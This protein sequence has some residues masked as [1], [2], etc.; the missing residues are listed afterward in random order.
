[1]ITIE[2]I[3]EVLAGQA[4]LDTIPDSWYTGK[5]VVRARLQEGMLELIPV[6]NDKINIMCYCC[7]GGEPDKGTF[8]LDELKGAVLALK[9]H[10]CPPWPG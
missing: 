2:Q 9:D 10:E 8:G 4:D 6:D 3:K 1:M 5:P 7:F